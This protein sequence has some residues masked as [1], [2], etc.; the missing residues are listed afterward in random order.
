MVQKEAFL[1]KRC[2]DDNK[3]M[4]ALKHASTF[5]TELRT[6]M[7][8]PKNYYELYMTVTD[9]M[10][11][12]EQFLLDEFKQG[13]KVNDLYELVQYAGNILP[14]LYLLIT[15]GSVYV[16]SNEV[17]SKKILNDLV[18]MCRGVQH[19]L[20]GLFLRNYLLTCLKS[21]LPTNLTSEDGNLADSIGFILTNFSEMNKLWVRMQHQG[22]SR[23]RTKREEERMQLRLLVGTNL[24]RIS[25]LDNLTLDDY[26]ERILPYILEQ[27]VS[28]KDAIAQEYLLEC[29]IQVFPD[30]FHLH[31]LSS[32]L[33]TCGKVRPQVNLKTIVISLIERLASYAQADPT[34]VPSEISLFHIFRQQLAGITEARPELPSEDVAAMYSSLAN[35]AMSCY[36]EQLGYVDE[37][38][39]STAD[40]IKQAGLS[41][42]EAASAVSNELVKLIKLP[43]NKYKDINTV[44]KLKHFTAFLPSFA[45]AT[46]NEIAVSVLRK[47]SE[48][49]DTLQLVEEIEPML[50][51]LQPLTEDQ[52]DCPSDFWDEEEFASEQGLLCAFVAQLRPD[53]RDVHFQ[54]LSALRKAFYNGTRRRMKFTLPALVFQC[55]QLAIAYYENREEDEA[56]EKKCSKIFQFSRATVLKL[57]E[58]DEFQLALKMFLQCALAV[59]RTEFEK[60]EALAY[61]FCSQAFVV[62]EEDI[63]DSKEQVEF[64]T[65]IIG[66]LQQMRVFGEENYNPLSTKCA[67]VSAKLVKKPDQVRCVCLCANL[68]WSG[69]TT[70]KG[71][72]LHDGKQVFQCLQKAVKVAKSC[73]ESAVQVALYTEIFNVYLLYF[74]RGCESVELLHLEKI[75]SMIQEKLEEV[76][77]SD[78]SLPDIR[79]ALEATQRHVEL[80]QGDDKLAKLKEFG[81]LMAS[82]A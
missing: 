46:R 80:L 72:E 53:A 52:K 60:T 28:C 61:E 8:Y 4:D 1:M 82:K 48:R 37:V 35:L 64:I 3:I 58:I 59:N 56:W 79:A 11:H 36:P 69:Y 43:V 63:S 21:E 41:N 26:D 81:G 33:E 12:L 32:L 13:R 45:F 74:Q 17:P 9:E 68:F 15:V 22:H 25:S 2:L 71:G 42:I 29:I 66:T 40:Y 10:R 24:V 44:L 31:T 19:P 14:R 18:D 34:R 54:I 7:L 57:T 77:D 49:G 27:I 5:L 39:Q 75:A 23:D 76:D 51:L 65:Q 70:D 20:R 67:V 50:A 47:M 30:E 78:E 55:N 73:I 6:S 62:Y 38:L 16:K